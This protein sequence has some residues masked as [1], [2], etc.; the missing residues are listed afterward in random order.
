MNQTNES[1]LGTAPLGKLIFSLALP[2]VVAQLVN[3]LYSI[4]D[5]IYIGHIAETGALALT[6]LGLCTPIILIVSAF[7]AF[8][9][10]GGAPLASM[11]LGQGDR[12]K[13]GKILSNSFVLL[14][15]FSLLLTVLLQLC[16]LPLLRFFGASDETIVYA[17]QYISIYLYGTLFVQLALGLNQFISC[18]GQATTAMVSVVIGAVSNIVLDPIFI[19]LLDMGVQGAALATVISQALSAAWNLRFL[20]SKRSA[21]RVQRKY[22]LPDGPVLRQIAALGI[23][24]F[25]MQSTECLV[26]IVFTR[27]LKIY[28]SDLYVG[29]YT[30]LHSVSQLIFIPANGFSFGAQPIISYNYGA[31]KYGRVRRCFRIMTCVLLGYTLLFYL[32]I[33]CFPR[34]LAGMFTSNA[35]LLALSAEKLPVF[36]FGM[37]IFGLQM[38]AQSMLLGT[39]QAKVSLFIACLRKVI[40]LT[41]LALLLPLAIGVDGVYLA[42]PISDVISAL[43]AGTI[44]FLVS[45]RLLRGGDKPAAEPVPEPVPAETTENSD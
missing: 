20:F 9:G 14:L 22:L 12:D 16:R 41:P 38:G 8:A 19:F 33:Y 2:A 31:G 39:G 5:R 21:I 36:M 35:E 29:T 15:I 7:A 10:A 18:Q 34:L 43:C 13:A 44:A 25:I 26:S 24:P 6:G 1:R 27:G 30:I 11:A 32:L 28:G 23:S 37:S 45:R 40:L 42:E 3:L 4:V 17:D